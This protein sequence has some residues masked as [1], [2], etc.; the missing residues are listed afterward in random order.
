MKLR[1]VPDDLRKIAD[2][3]SQIISD[4]KGTGT[5]KPVKRIPVKIPAK[6]LPLNSYKK[7]L[8]DELDRV[9]SIKDEQAIFVFSK[10]D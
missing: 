2:L 7:F 3:K 9:D 6:E 5:E 10:W 1:L 8:T 4:G